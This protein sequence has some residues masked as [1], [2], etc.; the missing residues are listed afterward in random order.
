VDRRTDRSPI[1]EADGR[2][3]ARIGF[4]QIIEVMFLDAVDSGVVAHVFVRDGWFAGLY[5]VG[6][7]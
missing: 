7:R 4:A 2:D 3:C 6:R 5:P 1:R